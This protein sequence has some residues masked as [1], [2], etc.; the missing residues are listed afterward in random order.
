M[1]I[2]KPGSFPGETAISKEEYLRWFKQI[3]AMNAN[4]LRIY[5][6]HPPEFYEAFYEYNQMADEPLYLF[7]GAWVN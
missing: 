6:I 1:G 2:A 4:A 3:G 7:H 5:T